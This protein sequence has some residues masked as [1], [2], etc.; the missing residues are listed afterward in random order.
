MLFPA[1]R[2]SESVTLPTNMP[3]TTSSVLQLVLANVQEKV[4]YQSSFQ[5]CNRECLKRNFLAHHVES[6][7]LKL[8]RLRLVNRIDSL[9][10]ELSSDKA[11]NKN[12]KS[13]LNDYLVTYGRMIRGKENRLNL[14]N[15]LKEILS[16]R[17]LSFDD[18]LAQDLNNQLLNDMINVLN[19]PTT[20]AQQ[21]TS[22]S[23]EQLTKESAPK[24][25]TKSKKS[26]TAAGKLANKKDE[27]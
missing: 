4:K 6:K 23:R 3:I 2:K 22:S 24:K 8:Q 27:L 10:R 9:K 26:K 7:E 1:K 11:K 15:N 21:A 20:P 25:A 12:L 18:E 19:A 17:M 16:K 14:F 13:I 5:L